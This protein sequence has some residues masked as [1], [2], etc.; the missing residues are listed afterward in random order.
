M[1]RVVSV[2]GVATAGRHSYW[3]VENH[4]RN[5]H[6]NFAHCKD[7][8]VTSTWQRFIFTRLRQGLSS[9]SLELCYYPAFT[10]RNNVEAM[11]RHNV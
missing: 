3:A 5:I 8:V 6:I 11:A 2:D 9:V 4:L 10:S 7:A 1:T